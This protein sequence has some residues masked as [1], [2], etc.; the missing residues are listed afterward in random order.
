MNATM[1]IHEPQLYAIIQVK[2][3]IV[4]LSG[5]SQNQFYL[6][7]VQKQ[8]RLISAVTGQDFGYP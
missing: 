4:L 7:K 6:Y 2:F 1:R 3:A 5:R 8:A